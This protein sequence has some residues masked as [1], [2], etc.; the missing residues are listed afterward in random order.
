MTEDLSEIKRVL[1]S[2]FW[3]QKRLDADLLHLE[4]LRDRAE[5]IGTF[6]H[7]KARSA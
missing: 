1:R 6:T 7:R 3:I 5:S 4:R 2:V